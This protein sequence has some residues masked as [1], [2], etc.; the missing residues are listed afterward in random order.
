[1]DTVL[2]AKNSANQNHDQQRRVKSI[3][4]ARKVAALNSLKDHVMKL[5][6]G[7]AKRN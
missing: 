2:D 3:Y 4:K 1:M 5:S 7:K 6:K